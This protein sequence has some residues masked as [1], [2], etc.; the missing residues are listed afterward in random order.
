MSS[1]AYS[2]EIG[3]L[4][5]ERAKT[6]VEAIPQRRGTLTGLFG[7]SGNNNRGKSPARH[8]NS[9]PRSCGGNATSSAQTRGSV[10]PP[11]L[12]AYQP[13]PPPTPQPPAKPAA[14]TATVENSNEDM[15]LDGKVDFA[16]DV[17]D[18]ETKQAGKEKSRASTGSKS[19]KEESVDMKKPPSA[20]AGGLSSEDARVAQ[21]EANELWKEIQRGA[22]PLAEISEVKQ[23][24][25]DELYIAHDWHSLFTPVKRWHNCFHVF[26]SLRLHFLL[27]VS[28]N[29]IVASPHHQ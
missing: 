21:S 9:P 23:N 5:G 26:I 12:S 27:I 19:G 1:K 20:A 3:T 15:D 11:R 6:L 22:V 4:V 10:T 29:S 28:F 16:G 24:T 8:G 7:S 25:F 14:L 17:S 13:P 2:V 18:E